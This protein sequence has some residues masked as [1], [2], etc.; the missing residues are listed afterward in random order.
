MGPCVGAGAADCHA[1]SQP[2]CR[3]GA[4]ALCRRLPGCSSFKPGVHAP[5]LD[6]GWTHEPDA[7]LEDSNL[8]H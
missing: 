5:R 3:G 6:G 1:G 4:D 8:Y 2:W 7:A